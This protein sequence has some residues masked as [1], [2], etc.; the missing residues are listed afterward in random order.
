MPKLLL[1]CH[2]YIRYLRVLGEY[3]E[4]GYD[5]DRIYVGGENE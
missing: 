3:R 4:M 2:E 1:G 5:V